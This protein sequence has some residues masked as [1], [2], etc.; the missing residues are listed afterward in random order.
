[1]SGKTIAGVWS[2]IGAALMNGTPVILWLEEDEMPPVFPQPVG[3]WTVNPQAEVGYW[4][5]FGDPPRFC[6][7]RYIRGWRPCL[8]K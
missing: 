8:R 4:R 7:D 6:S 2:P 1:V 3:F 5:L